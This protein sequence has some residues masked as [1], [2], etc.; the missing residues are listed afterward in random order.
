MKPTEEKR[1][2]SGSP[3]GEAALQVNPPQ[4]PVRQSQVLCFLQAIT[5]LASFQGDSATCRFSRSHERGRG[6]DLPAA[7]GW[8]A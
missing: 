1:R 5:C 3:L 8:R 2:R 7:P 6:G 4:S